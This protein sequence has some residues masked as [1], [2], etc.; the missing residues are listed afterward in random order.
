MIIL[1]LHGF[2]SSPRSYKATLIK[3]RISLIEKEVAFFCP[4]LPPS[5][6]KS[7]EMILKIIEKFKGNFFSIIGSSLGGFYA[8]II[9]EKFGCKA[10][11]L[12][13]AINP[14]NDLLRYVNKN[15]YWHTDDTF[16]FKKDY[17]Q[18]LKKLKIS[19]VTFPD[20]YFLLAS[21]KDEVIDWKEM[22]N[23]YASV[24]KKLLIVI[25]QFQIL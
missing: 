16:N 20:R 19:K 23:F 25:M 5:P 6:H 13:P 4:Q 10:A 7:V 11:L 1:Y 14:A 8:T 21:K 18:E 12:N 15:K 22:V 17:I 9:A 2:R 3:K 24:K